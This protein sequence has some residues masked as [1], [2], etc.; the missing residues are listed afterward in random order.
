MRQPTRPRE[1]PLH[2]VGA[3]GTL[4]AEVDRGS[5]VE[6]HPAVHAGRTA[7]LLL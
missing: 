6:A 3:A 1:P 5:V 7:N 2:A 4:L